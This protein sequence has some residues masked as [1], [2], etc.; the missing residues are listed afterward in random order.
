MKFNCSNITKHF[1]NKLLIILHQLFI[2]RKP[3]QLSALCWGTHLPGLWTDQRRTFLF[4]VELIKQNEEKGPKNI[5][6]LCFSL[7][8]SHLN[9][10]FFDFYSLSAVARGSKIDLIRC[11][12]R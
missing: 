5:F 9:M 12:T 10:I 2:A 1:A 6:H 11:P 7:S 4:E 3:N 8:F